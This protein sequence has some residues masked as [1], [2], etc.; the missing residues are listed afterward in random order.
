MA[1]GCGPGGTQGV[2]AGDRGHPPKVQGFEGLNEKWLD[3]MDEE[4]G[5]PTPQG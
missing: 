4:M 5:H 1:G 3:H 2:D